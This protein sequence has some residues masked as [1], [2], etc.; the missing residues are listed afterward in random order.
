MKRILQSLQQHEVPYEEEIQ[1]LTGVASQA[2]LAIEN[3]Q[4][5]AAKVD[6]CEKLETRKKVD[7]AK[8]ILIQRHQIGEDEAYR[9]IQKKSMDLRKN[10]KEIADAIIISEGM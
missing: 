5:L 2:A 8:H 1:L 10:V 6:A 7:Q 3:T 4:L 9:L